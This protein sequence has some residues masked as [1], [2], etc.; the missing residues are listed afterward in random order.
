M[1]VTTVEAE[2]VTDETAGSVQSVSG[3]FSQTD[4]AAGRSRATVQGDGQSV[5]SILII[6]CFLCHLSINTL[7]A[8]STV[9][10]QYMARR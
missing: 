10:S 4:E 7:T 3:G 8:H 2:T 1:T 6:Q 5:L 9:L